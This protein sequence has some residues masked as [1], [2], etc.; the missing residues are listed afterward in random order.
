MK[1]VWATYAKQRIW[2]GN[3]LNPLEDEEVNSPDHH[4]HD[5][6]D[7]ESD[8]DVSGNISET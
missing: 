8:V 7:I 5:G 2:T 4:N 6:D 3:P 1:Q